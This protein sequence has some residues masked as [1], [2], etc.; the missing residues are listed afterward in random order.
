MDQKMLGCSVSHRTARRAAAAAQANPS[1]FQQSIQRAAMDRN[2]TDILDLGTGNRLV[3]GNHRQGFESSARQ[4]AGFMR[5]ARQQIAQILGRAEHPAARKPHQLHAA[6]VVIG[7]QG[8]KHPRNRQSDRQAGLQHLLAQRL[9]G[10]KQQG[11]DHTGGLAQQLVF[12]CLLAAMGL[13]EFFHIDGA[14]Q[15]ASPLRPSAPRPS[16]ATANGWVSPA[17]GP[18]AKRPRTCKGAK[19]AS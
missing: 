2:A 8:L 19:A 15:A 3:I 13:P 5:L 14:H 7:L 12:R 10:G 18:P 17:R 1:G 11:L 6:L 16:S 4:F 9:G